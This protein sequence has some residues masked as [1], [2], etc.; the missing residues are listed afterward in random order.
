MAARTTPG[1]RGCPGRHDRQLLPAALAFRTRPSPRPTRQRAIHC[2]GKMQVNALRHDPL[3]RMPQPRLHSLEQHIRLDSIDESRGFL[4]VAAPWRHR[5][6][7]SNPVALRLSDRRSW[8]CPGG[9]LRHRPPFR[10][11]F[12]SPASGTRGVLV[13]GGQALLWPI[14][15]RSRCKLLCSNSSGRCSTNSVRSPKLLC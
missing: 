10:S 7:I 6:P 12:T 11:R 1:V 9:V 4:V 5:V 2:E 13:T 14:R 15:S 8:F 3:V